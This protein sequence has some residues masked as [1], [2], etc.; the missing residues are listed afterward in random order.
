[1]Q[2][3]D[4]IADLI[5]QR[6]RDAP[7]TALENVAADNLVRDENRAGHTLVDSFERHGIL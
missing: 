5:G 2:A 1:M 7:G 6:M 4:N 3:N